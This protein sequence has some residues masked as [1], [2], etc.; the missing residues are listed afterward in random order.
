MRMLPAVVWMAI[1]YILSD[2]PSAPTPPG[3]D[4][5]LFFYASHA[6]VYG[7]LAL[8]LVFAMNT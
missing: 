3:V 7:I 6:A 1:I 5:E 4:D 2:R 8:R